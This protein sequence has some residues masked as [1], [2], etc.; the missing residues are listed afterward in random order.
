MTTLSE[1]FPSITGGPRSSNS[2]PTVMLLLLLLGNLMSLILL[3]APIVS[4]ALDC[5]Q[6]TEQASM[7]AAC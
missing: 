4:F 7:C 6:W 5:C 2:S 3:S 1:T